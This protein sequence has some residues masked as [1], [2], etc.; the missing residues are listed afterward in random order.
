MMATLQK[1]H[2]TVFLYNYVLMSQIME[3]FNTD[4]SWVATKDLHGD[5][6]QSWPIPRSGWK[7]DANGLQ[8]IFWSPS[9]VAPHEQKKIN[10]QNLIS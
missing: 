2:Q 4:S 7:Y 3:A 8:K 10:T 9:G 5:L 1:E 6:G